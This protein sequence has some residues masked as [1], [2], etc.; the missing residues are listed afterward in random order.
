[1][2]F[3]ITGFLLFLCIVTKAQFG[4]S[5][6]VSDLS[7][8]GFNS[9]FKERILTE[10]RFG[11][12]LASEELSS[13]LITTYIFRKREDHEIY[14]GIGMQLRLKED[15]ILVLPVGINYYPF[16]KK[17]FGLHTEVAYLAG[18][19]DIIRGSVG[20]RYRFLFD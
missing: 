15:G 3:A 10:L 2:K 16:V 5:Y 17:S 1:M 12:N 8:V 6:H 7:F 11:T 9:T 13:E 20:I 18:E 19:E 14:L 4:I